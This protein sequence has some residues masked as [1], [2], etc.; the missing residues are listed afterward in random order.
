MPK[1]K[2][3]KRAF[4]L[5]SRSFSNPISNSGW[6]YG[7]KRGWVE[8][9]V[10]DD[11]LCRYVLALRDGLDYNLAFIPIDFHPKRALEF[12]TNYYI[13][14]KFN[15]AFELACSGYKWSKYPPGLEP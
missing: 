9:G 13:N 4:F 8:P 3:P 7:S 2:A 11:D 1:V 14:Q 15:L 6:K 10:S 5:A 12:D